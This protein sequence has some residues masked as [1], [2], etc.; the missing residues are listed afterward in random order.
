MARDGHYAEAV[1]HQALGFTIARQAGMDPPLM[2][3]LVSVSVEGVTLEGM[4]DILR[5]AGPNEDAADAVHSAV[6]AYRPTYD[7]TR[8]LRAEMMRGITFYAHIRDS[9]A[10]SYGR[11]S[12][13]APRDNP[14]LR[15]YW[16]W[17]DEAAY[18]HWMTGNI[19]ASRLT[20]PERLKALKLHDEEMVHWLDRGPVT[21]PVTILASMLLVE[22]AKVDARLSQAAAKR[23]VI[24]GAAAVLA[25]KA[26]HGISP[27]TLDQAVSPAPVDPL[28]G[29]PLEYRATGSGFQIAAQP[30]TSGMDPAKARS[31]IESLKFEYPVEQGQ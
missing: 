5:E 25:Y 29:Q 28:T 19:A 4:E 2:G 30:D 26:R 15:K 13:G 9:A 7:L 17:P 6:A 1:R 11:Q 14:V 20:E 8:S 21:N 31:L 18:I 27:N 10:Q 12:G 24:E 3:Q 23:E 16:L 22:G